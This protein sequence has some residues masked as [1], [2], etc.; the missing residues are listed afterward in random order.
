[1]HWPIL[2]TLVFLGGT[3]AA[4]GLPSE[5][6][7]WVCKPLASAG[8]L[9]TAFD[10]GAWDSTYGRIILG[11]LVLSW[12]GDVLLIPLNNKK[13]FLVGLLAFLGAHFAFAAAFL[14]LGIAPLWLVSLV[15]LTAI[16]FAFHRWLG[17]RIPA[18]LAKA[19]VVYMAVITV[20]V[21]L[22]GGA[23]GHGAP[24]IIPLGAF[25][26]WLSDLSVALDRFA[27]Y[28]FGNRL[29]GLPA[30]YGAQLLLAW[31]VGLV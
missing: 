28:G 14:T 4:E 31:S 3:L 10:A 5:R 26:F 30:Y 1:M 8:F 19:V 2:F 25:I 29:W 20:M 21:A 9:W 16:V 27:H 24:W 23:Y 11:A 22:S 13:A 15:P 7:K 17:D 6:L 12:F 18:K